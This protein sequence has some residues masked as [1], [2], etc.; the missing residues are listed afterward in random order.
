MIILINMWKKLTKKDY[1]KRL[2][3]NFFKLLNDDLFWKKYTFAEPSFYNIRK[4]RELRA[5]IIIPRSKE[6]LMQ[7]VETYKMITKDNRDNLDILIWL[8]TDANNDLVN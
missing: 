4:M 3:T 1:N 6:F 5:K 7:F 8:F 2:Q